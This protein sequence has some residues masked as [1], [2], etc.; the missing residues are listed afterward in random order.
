M[1]IITVSKGRATETQ[2]PRRILRNSRRINQT[3]RLDSLK[4]H[5]LKLKKDANEELEETSPTKL[6]LLQ[7]IQLNKKEMLDKEE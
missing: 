6:I 7:E 1:P 4:T 3:I 5:L 2:C